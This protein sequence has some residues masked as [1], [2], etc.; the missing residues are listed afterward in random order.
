[1]TKNEGR[2][3]RDFDEFTECFG[4]GEDNPIGLKL[5]FRR[6]GD[7]AKAE[8]VP[9][10]N[11]QGWPGYVHGGIINTLLDEAMAYPAYY[12]G[13]YCV[14]AKMETR[15][16][17]A[18]APGQRLLISSWISETRKK[19]VDTMAEIKLDDGTVIAEAKAAM[20]II[21]KAERGIT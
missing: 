1:M 5:K 16:R 2:S 6:E 12:S 8:F 3:L 17:K 10:E 9:T 20:Y 11:H 18:T 4:C 15:F 14:T 13:L 7:V 19:V 21:E